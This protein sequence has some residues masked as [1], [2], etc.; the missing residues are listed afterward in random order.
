MTQQEV[1]VLFGISPSTLK[2]WKADPQNKK[3]NLGIYLAALDFETAKKEVEK[4]Q[5][6]A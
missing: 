1:K 4:V 3:H 5:K 6:K 2:E